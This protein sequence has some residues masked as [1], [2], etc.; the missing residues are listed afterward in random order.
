[1]SHVGNPAL[2]TRSQLRA[3]WIIAISALA[4]LLAATAVALVLFIDDGGSTA[5][6]SIATPQ[7]A[8]RSDGG[9]NESAVAVSVGTRPSPV[10]DESAVAAA[11]GTATGPTPVPDEAAIGAA[12]RRSAGPS[13]YAA[14]GPDES[15]V[16][17]SIS[18]R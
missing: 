10:P 18:G 5:S 12:I 16:A 6:R 7:A 9:P 2:S 15:T 17:A 3:H 4:A 14:D 11:V 13:E 1:M 8:V